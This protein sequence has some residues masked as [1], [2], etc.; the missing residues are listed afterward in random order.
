MPGPR[1]AGHVAVVG[2]RRAHHV[3][4]SLAAADCTLD[5]AVLKEIDSLMTGST[6]VDG[7]SPE[8]M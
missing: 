4:D 5:D 3:E 2:S 8:G 7:P 1:S 6:Q